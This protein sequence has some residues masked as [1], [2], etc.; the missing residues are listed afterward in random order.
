MHK[1]M[2]NI[3][4][5]CIQGLTSGILARKLNMIAE[6]RNEAYSFLSAGIADAEKHLDWADYLILTPQVRD[7]MQKAEESAAAHGVKCLILADT[8]ISFQKTVDTYENIV[9][10]ISAQQKTADHITLG[11]LTETLVVIA[12]LIAAGLCAYII[13]RMTGSTAMKFIY[14]KTLG[15]ICLYALPALGCC[16]FRRCSESRMAGLLTGLLVLLSLTPFH[17]GLVYAEDA[18]RVSRRITDIRFWGPVYL[19]LYLAAGCLFLNFALMAARR[20]WTYYSEKR[21][22]VADRQFLLYAAVPMI[23]VMCVLLMFRTIVFSLL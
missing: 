12:P 2:K 6:E 21:H 1:L 10:A 19:P 13:S 22:E 11:S 9:K 18:F 7:R 17:E 23:M 16:M 4:I 3:L 5:I 20:M 8:M 15:V 14:D